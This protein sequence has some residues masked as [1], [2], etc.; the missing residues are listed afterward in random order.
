MIEDA[1]VLQSEFVPQEVEHRDAEVN[2]LSNALDPITQG[3]PAET[4]LL[5]G[6]SGVGKTCIAQFTLERL[7]E[8]VID[9]EF[10]YVNCWQDYSRFRTLYRILDGVGETIDIHRQSTPH[11]ELLERLRAYGGPQYVIILDEVDQ[12]EDTRVL[13]DLYQIPK[14]S[15]V[16]IANREEDLFGKLDDRLVSRLHSSRRIRFNKYGIDELVAIMEARVR[17]GLHEDAIAR[18]Q[19]GRIADTAAGDA[20]IAIGILRSAARE[21]DRQDA[22]RITDAIL[23]DAIP[24]ARAAVQQSNVEKLTDHQH[25]LYE[26]IREQKEIDPGELYGQYQERVAEPRTNRTVRNYLQK[27]AHYNLIHSRG[28]GRGRIYRIVE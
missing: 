11:D 1:R 15:M 20:R 10:Q 24:E 28:E 27:M 17:W 13:Y 18:P 19:L 22:T 12:L 7:R 6:P 2:Q 21:A 8:A 25:V 3:E 5:F 4:V 14:I 26:I 16:L 23:E 9:I